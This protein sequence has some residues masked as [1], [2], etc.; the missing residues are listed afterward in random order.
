MDIRT[1]KAKRAIL[2]DEAKTL[3]AGSLNDETRAKLDGLMKDATTL[4]SDIERAETLESEL[5][6]VV[7]SEGTRAGKP[8]PV[9]LNLKTKRGETPE[10]V[11][12]HYYRTG[13]GSRELRAS[14]ANDMTVGDATYAG[15]A[16]PTGHFQG[17]IAKRDQIALFG[18][19]GVTNIPGK[20]TTV[21]VTYDNG[22]AEL[23]VSTNEAAAFDVD[24]PIVGR[25]AFTLVKYTK[26][27]TL[28][29]ELMEDEDANLMAYVEQYVGRALGLTENSLLVTEALANGTSV[30][31][32]NTAIATASDVNTLMYSLKGEY[33]DGAQWLMTRATEGAYRALTGSA[34]LFVPT[35]QGSMNTLWGAPVQNSSAMPAIGSGNKSILFGNFAYVGR[36][37]NGAMTVLRDPYS[38]AGTGQVNL[39]FSTR[40]VYKVLIAEAIRY[41]KHLTTT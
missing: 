20:G 19:L 36:R 9:A 7:E 24:A 25:H 14:N 12:A 8:E 40:L 33:A 5:F 11:L 27:I 16:V 3:G 10:S 1:M 13:D 41:G 34:F 21:N 4:K 29:E 31:L 39:H 18:K 30:N 17:I 23:F 28:S 38:A 32:A 37:S 22:S 35:P 15:Y 6:S 26:K 2:L